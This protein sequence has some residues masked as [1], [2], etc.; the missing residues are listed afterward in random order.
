MVRGRVRLV[1]YVPIS[2]EFYR[3]PH[4]PQNLPPAIF[5]VLLPLSGL[6]VGFGAGYFLQAVDRKGS[7]KLFEEEQ[8][9]EREKGREK[10]RGRERERKEERKEGRERKKV[11]KERA[12]S[13]LR[14]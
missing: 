13:G 12:L 1:S 2:R 6:L 8:E 11:E 7:F 14:T 9:R 4:T 3:I 10:E 5:C